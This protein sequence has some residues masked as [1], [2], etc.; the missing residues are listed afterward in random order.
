MAAADQDRL[1][2]LESE[3]AELRQFVKFTAARVQVSF[4]DGYELGRESILGP[5]AGS[6]RAARTPQAKRWLH[7]VPEPAAEAE[8]ELDLGVG[9]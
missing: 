6:G 8:A 4:N 5:G 2:A 7:A 9:A 1:A 3:V